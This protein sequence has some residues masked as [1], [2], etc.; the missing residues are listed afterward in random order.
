[1]KCRDLYMGIIVLL[2]AAAADYAMSKRPQEKEKSD[3]ES[4]LI[5]SMSEKKSVEGSW[6]FLDTLNKGKEIALSENDFKPIMP[7]STAILGDKDNKGSFGEGFRI[8]CFASSQIDRIRSEQKQLEIKVKYPVYVIFNAPYYKL[9][10][11][12]FAKRGDADAALG[13]LKEIGYNDAW[14]ARSKINPVR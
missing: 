9:L 1:M 6:T 2:I 5:V 14:V 4:P 10:V 13:K 3:D 7:E 11:G 12:D 8:Q